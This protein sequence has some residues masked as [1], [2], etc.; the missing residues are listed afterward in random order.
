MQTRLSRFCKE[1]VEV[2][3]RL[4]GDR[5]VS[6]AVYGSWAR[7]MATPVSDIDVLVIAEDLPSSRRKRV[8]QFEAVERDTEQTRRAIWGNDQTS[9]PLSPV[10]KTKNE[11]LAGSPLFLDM[12]E[13]CEI[14]WDWEGFL[15]G[16]LRGLRKRMRALG[17]RRRRAKG[18]YYWEY[19]PDLRPG[20]VVEL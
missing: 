2:S 18:G 8:A 7:G 4:Y 6:L 5:L 11:A 1:L 15:D 14:L 16:Y 13:W 17:T 3:Q 10:I 20:E 12:T 9:P 19:K